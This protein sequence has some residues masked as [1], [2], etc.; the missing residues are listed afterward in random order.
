MNEQ[1]QQAVATMIQ[2]ALEAFNKGASFM[3]AEIPDVV[4]QLLRW[5]AVRSAAM[6][7][8]GVLILVVFVV[9][10]YYQ[11]KWWV[12][13]DPNSRYDERRIDMAYGPAVL[14]NL[15][16]ILPVAF[17]IGTINLTWLQIWIAPK[18]W[19]IEYA[20]KMIK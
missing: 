11:V 6:T 12:A 5:H 9:T 1:L 17:A 16:W 15:I 20:A 18:V 2:Q 14:L 3:A 10:S 8:L 19:L 7:A 13:K 4:N